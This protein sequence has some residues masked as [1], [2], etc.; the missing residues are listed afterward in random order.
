MGTP[1]ISSQF[2][3]GDSF[4]DTALIIKVDAV[5]FNLLWHRNTKKKKS[6]HFGTLYD[7]PDRF[8]E[9]RVV[10]LTLVNQNIHFHFVECHKTI[11]KVARRCRYLWHRTTEHEELVCEGTSRPCVLGSKTA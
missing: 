7:Y 2:I 8:G 3:P 6:E 9:A 1:N 4:S 5:L 10:S 11:N